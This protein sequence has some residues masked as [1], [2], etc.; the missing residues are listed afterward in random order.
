MDSPSTVTRNGVPA[1]AIATRR[2]QSTRLVRQKLSLPPPYGPVGA[3]VRV[4]SIVIT[5]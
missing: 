5:R 4:E 1:R 2:R 3:R